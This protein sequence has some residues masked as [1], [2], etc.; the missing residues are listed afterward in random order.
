MPVF[1]YSIFLHFIYLYIL[2][3][4]NKLE[5]VHGHDHLEVPKSGEETGI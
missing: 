3:W 4:F 2:K 1:L 5:S